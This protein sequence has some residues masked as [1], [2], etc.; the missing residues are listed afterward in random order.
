MGLVVLLLVAAVIA[1][2]LIG[3]S[4]R[5]GLETAVLAWLSIY[6]C[7]LAVEIPHAVAWYNEAGILLLDGEGAESAGVDALGAVLQP[8]THSAYIFLSVSQLIIAVLAAAFGAMA[9][10]VRDSSVGVS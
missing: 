9:L 6:V 4:F 2:T 10:R 5:A 1:G 3:R 7:S 8:L